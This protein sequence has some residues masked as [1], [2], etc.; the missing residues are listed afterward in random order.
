MKPKLL[1]FFIDE[2][3]QID[4]TINLVDDIIKLAD[5]IKTLII[6]QKHLS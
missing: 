3:T 2:T 6:F 5:D 4:D 1:S